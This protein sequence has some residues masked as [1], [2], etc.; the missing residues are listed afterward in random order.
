[1]SFIASVALILIGAMF[2]MFC[3]AAVESYDHSK[4][5]RTA[6]LVVFWGALGLIVLLCA[7]LVR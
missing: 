5:E 3:G 1:M 7:V 2:C 6:M 4:S